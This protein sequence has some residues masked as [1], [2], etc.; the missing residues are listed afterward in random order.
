MKKKHLRTASIIFLAVIVVLSVSLFVFRDMITLHPLTEEHELSYPSYVSGNSDRIA[1][2]EDS[3]KSVVVMHPDGKLIYKLNA[4]KGKKSFST[5]SFLAMDE[6]NNLYV[7]D[8]DINGLFKENRERVLKFSPEG[9]FLEILYEYSYTNHNFAI[10]LGRLN[11][12]TYFEGNVYFVRPDDNGFWLERASTENLGAK[13]AALHFFEYPNARRDLLYF[14]INVNTRRVSLTSR[15]GD[16]K[17][18]DFNGSLV[19]ERSAVMGAQSFPWT[20]VSD[21]YNNLVYTDILTGNIV[22]INP[23]Q[24]RQA[25]L[26]A[27][28]ENESPFYRLAYINNTLF[29]VDFF[30]INAAYAKDTSYLQSGVCEFK[31]FHSYA[32]SL[33]TTIL[34]KIL[35]AVLAADVLAVLAFIAFI[36]RFFRRNISDKLKTIF[37]VG[38][39][40]AFG[41]IIS[42]V[43]I[44]NEMTKQ[45]Q[46]KAYSDLEN[47]SRLM[48]ASLDAD[49]LDNIVSP[50]QYNSEAY[51]RFA[52]RLRAMFGQMHFTGERVYQM[53]W[54]VDEKNGLVYSIYDLEGALGAM[55]PFD[56]YAEDSYYRTVVKTREYV[57]NSNVTVNGSWQ[58]V[59]GPILDPKG[60]VTGLIETGH[61][62]QFVHEQTRKMVIQIV[63]IVIVASI[64]LLLI[65]IECILILSAYKQNKKDQVSRNITIKPNILKLT[66][67]FIVDEYKKHKE[68]NERSIPERFHPE[69]LRAVIFLAYFTGNI[70]S[71]FLPIY[72]VKLYRPLLNLPHEL[73]VALPMA[74]DMIFAALALLIVPGLLSRCGPKLMALLAAVLAL[75]SNVLCFTSTNTAFLAAAYALSGFAG[76]A[77]LLVV[78]A[79]IGGRRNVEDVNN[80]FAHF[81]ASYL[82]GVNV[83]VVFGSII[84]QFVSYRIVYLFSSFFALLLFAIIFYAVRSKQ[85]D[86]FF[87]FQ[88]QTERRK[89]SLV[90]FLISPAIFSALLLMIFPFVVSQSFINYFMPIFGLEHGLKES[91]IGQ[92]LLLNGLFAIL[93]GTALCEYAI[94]KI[95][96]KIIV[97]ASLLLNLGS[98]LIFTIDMSIPMLVLAV[99][100]LAVT[101]IFALT[102]MQTYYATL[103]QKTRLSSVKALSVYSAVENIAMAAGPVIFS[104]ILAGKNLAATLRIFA[105]ALLGCLVVFLLVSGISG[106]KKQ[107]DEAE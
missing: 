85:F 4:G 20:V 88:I 60:K 28:G 107:S 51:T 101:N 47:I 83:G 31:Y 35:F 82:A 71:A 17:Q 106:K 102:T 58:F 32:Y 55:Y 75:A 22:L 21:N 99:G 23:E 79:I 59:C 95:P 65:I 8:V 57:H 18:Y 70:P 68:K 48:A 44:I 7:L 36:I 33:Q 26:F 39:C 6:H 61:D 45:Y 84:A 97:T 14:H 87:K 11:G 40:I 24:N 1:I 90:K 5:V 92:L 34:K 104:Y 38:I 29:A 63:L 50:A 64:A 12:L 54:K 94:K 56:I 77:L 98:L 100:L 66:L 91:N 27:A 42:A 2:I 72:S 30:G 25:V 52:S 81:N 73:V 62:T 9:K 74:T 89:N 46:E 53:I 15:A 41:S 67:A 78:N 103:Y 49:F 93:F 3:E 76:G 105:A 69:L 80:G 43:L 16:I 37:L 10:T 13:P 19:Y 96:L 86:Y